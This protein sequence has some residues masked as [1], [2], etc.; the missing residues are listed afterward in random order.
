MSTTQ[1]LLSIENYRALANIQG[2]LW[3]TRHLHGPNIVLIL[4]PELNWILI[5]TITSL[6]LE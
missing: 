4:K 3:K 6:V 2:N 1:S 5:L